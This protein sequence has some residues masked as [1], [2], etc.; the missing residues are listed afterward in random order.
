M[1][2]LA[3][4]I[5]T[6]NT[7]WSY[8][9]VKKLKIGYSIIEHEHGNIA[10]SMTMTP[11]MKI[12]FFGNR[13]KELLEKYNPDEV[14]FEEPILVMGHGFLTARSLARFNGVGMYFAHQLIKKEVYSYEPSRWKKSLGLNSTC[15]KTEVQLEITKQMNLLSN[16]AY[17]KFNSEIREE[18]KKLDLSLQIETLEIEQKKEMA[19]LKEAIKANIPS[20]SV[21]VFKE[22][23][24]SEMKK[25]KEQLKKDKKKLAK[26]MDKNLVK[27]GTAI[28]SETGV[29]FDVADAYGVNFCMLKELSII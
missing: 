22:V 29:N 6:N 24:K 25:L 13:I 21:S 15:H 19:I 8:L 9:N 3:F 1:K 26:E 14:A 27:I 12:Y 11:C 20:M 18:R 23:Q 5:S 28:Y 7:G 16:D 2:T 10:P 4:D 17:Q